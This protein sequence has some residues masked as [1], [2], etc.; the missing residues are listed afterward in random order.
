MRETHT[1]LDPFFNAI[2]DIRGKNAG[3]CLWFAYVFWL[4]LKD[5][6]LPTD[7][8]GIVQY[9]YRGEG[10]IEHNQK[11]IDG[12]ME[13]R[14]CVSSSHFTWYYEGLEWDADG[15]FQDEGYRD[16]AR[17]LAGLNEPHGSLV[18]DFCK[19]ALRYAGWNDWFDRDT[20]RDTLQERF[21]FQ[22]P[23]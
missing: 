22:I 2:Q 3:G 18:D 20:A 4:W 19:N 5:N 10:C 12:K 21:G 16:E 6:N 23:A 8:F 15:E 7:S 9:Q 13:G 17:E 11:W 1:D 14:N